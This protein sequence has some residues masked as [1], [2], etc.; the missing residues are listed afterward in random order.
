MEQINRKW[1]ALAKSDEIP[2]NKEEFR[3]ILAYGEKRT[4]ET[5]LET[6]RKMGA[7]AENRGYRSEEII[8]SGNIAKE[9]RYTVLRWLSVL[10]AHGYLE[11]TDEGFSLSEPV[12]SDTEDERL[13][14][15]AAGIERYLGR[16]KPHL[17]A[18]LQGQKRPADIYY[19][20]NENLTPNDLLAQLP[21][22]ESAV[23]LQL[24]SL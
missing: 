19:V 11:N 3:K 15:K 16:L 7:F 24:L 23:R 6:L 9:Q 18:L 22:M 12:F 2:E 10:T 20:E 4:C 5:M 21:E 8:L 14:A 13:T 17:P 1:E